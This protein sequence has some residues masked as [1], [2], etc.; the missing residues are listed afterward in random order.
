MEDKIAVNKT[1]GLCGLDMMGS[2]HFHPNHC[3]AEAKQMIAGLRFLAAAFEDEAAKNSMSL[4]S[5]R[6]ALYAVLY[7]YSRNGDVLLTC[8]DLD[9]VPPDIGMDMKE[10]EHGTLELKAIE[11]PAPK[12]EMAQ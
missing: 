4:K 9:K 11:L 12:G 5:M 1:C 2:K 6:T 10:L 7:K 3:L 8:Q